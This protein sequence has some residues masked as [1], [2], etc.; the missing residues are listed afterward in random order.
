M[1]EPRLSRGAGCGLPSLPL[2]PALLPLAALLVCLAV[3]PRSS[4]AATVDARGR[5]RCRPRAKRVLWVSPRSPRIGDPLRLLA[6][7]ERDYPHAALA[8]L[9]PAGWQRLATSKGG[10][11]PHWWA[12]ELPAATAAPLQLALLSA[13]DEPLICATLRISARPARLSSSSA[14]GLEAAV[15]PRWPL[16]AEWSWATEA[17]YA[18]WVEHLFAAPADAGENW[19][20]SWSPLHQVLRDSQRNWLHNHLGLGEDGP[21]PQR[22]V[23]AEPDCADLPYFL[24]AY[25]AWKL[26]LPFGLRHCDR[27]GA[28]RPARC[29]PLQA[30][31]AGAAPLVGASAAQDFS[32]WL[33]QEVSLVHSGA[34][35]TA[36]DDDATDF[37]PLPLTRAALRPGAVYV[38]PY[39]HLLVVA[40]WQPQGSPGSGVLYAIDGHPDLS[41]GRK[42][43][44]RGAFL[45]VPGAE[46]GAGGFKA[47]RPLRLVDG[48]LVALTNEALRR[49]QAFVPP[50]LE[51][52]Q[53]GTEAF[54]ARMD[55]LIN[56]RPLVPQEALLER[57]RALHELMLERVEAVAAGERYLQQQGWP[58]VA[59]P[60]GPRIFETRGPWE[61]FSTPARDL[62]LLIAIDETIGFPAYVAR[63]A[64]RFAWPAGESAAAVRAALERLLAQQ[65]AA[66]ELSYQRSD[67]LRQPLTM[68]TVI[69]RREALELAYNPNDCVELRWGASGDELA[70]CQRHAP[71]EQRERMDRYR[72]WFARRQRPPLR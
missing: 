4:T 53:L 51:Q 35:R 56:P 34:G 11:P 39:G 15:H 12:A 29:G 30:P 23:V 20:P 43:F 33:R 14:R 18:A 3:V 58:V 64:K 1:T 47:F 28:A 27:G 48:A 46:G 37:Y 65:L 55:R 5:L 40:R 31:V 22:A 2:P 63:H 70:A 54:Y 13:A 9:G 8:L 32:R 7:A 21:D 52:Y 16:R 36:G 26:G 6:A 45:F 38:D 24:R 50:S 69:A 25:F 42:R 17:L 19:R 71:A 49:E 41:V 61:D 59:M 60:A 57:L 67:G 44:W 66:A 10:G 72:A 68:A 62:R